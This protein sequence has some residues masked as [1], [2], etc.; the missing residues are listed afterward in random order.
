[1]RRIVRQS[2]SSFLWGMRALPPKRR[3]AIYAVYAF[4]RLVDN[5]ADGTESLPAKQR[6]LAAWHTEID[7]LYAGQPQ[8]PVT[9]ALEA[10]VRDYQLPQE[11]FHA[12]IRGMETDALP[13][14]RMQTMNELRQYCRQVAGSVGLLCIHI[15]GLRRS[16]GPRF[17]TALGNAFQMTNILRDVQE[18]L[19]LNRLYL[20]GDLLQAHGIRAVPLAGLAE[21]QRL[22]Y[23]CSDLADLAYQEYAEAERCMQQLNWWRTRPAALMKAVYK[24]TL[25]ALVARGWSRWQEPLRPGRME[26]LWS[27]VRHGLR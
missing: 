15:F 13:E 25:D 7:L 9:R 18:D 22:A 11:E 19:T 16:P 8:H 26:Q 20:P 10:G 12:L 5:I 6:A 23:V 4:S 21:Q 27:V 2:G 17:A 3:N 14:V 24:T 1:M